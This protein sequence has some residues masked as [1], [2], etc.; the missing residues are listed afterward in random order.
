MNETFIIKIKY[1]DKDLPKIGK[2]ENGDWIDLYAAED[3]CLDQFESRLISLG[4]SME[5]PKGW[6]AHIVPRSSTFKKFGIIQTNHMGVVDSAYN[7]D[8]DVWMFPALAMR[9]TTIEKGTRICQFRIVENQPSILFHEVD[10]LGNSNRG[11][12][13]STGN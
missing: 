5:L 12:F 9:P 4:I 11:G 13:G 7:G 2:I 10:S 6:E 1:H 3:V 8:S